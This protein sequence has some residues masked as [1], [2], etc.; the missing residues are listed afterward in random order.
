MAK[1]AYFTKRLDKTSED[2]SS[3]ASSSIALEALAVTAAMA[4]VIAPGELINSKL[5]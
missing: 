1:N 2:N 5:D 3:D 4:A